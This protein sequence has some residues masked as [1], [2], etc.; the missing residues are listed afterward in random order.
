MSDTEL[1]QSAWVVALSRLPAMGPVR[2]SA[3][4]RRWSPPQA[5][6]Q[7]LSARVHLDEVIVRETRSLGPELSE[8]WRQVARSID[9]ADLW[10]AHQSSD[11]SVI[12]ANDPDFPNE[13]IDDP[14]PPPAL[15]YR[16]PL[17]VLSA[18][19]VAIVG[20]RRCTSAGK[21]IAYELGF[22]LAKVGV[23]VISGLALGID[24][25]AHRGALAAA[26]DGGAPPAGVVGTGLDVA[27]PPKNRQ[28]WDEVGQEGLLI[29][30]YPLGTTPEPWR[31]PARNRIIASLSEVVVVVE[32]HMQGGSLHTVESALER[33]KAVMAVPGSVRSSASVGTNELLAAGC[34][35][36]RD[37]N[38]VLVALGLDTVKSKTPKVIDMAKTSDVNVAKI[39]DCLGHE[40]ATLEQLSVRTR[41]SPVPLAASLTRLKSQGVV[42]CRGS[43]WERR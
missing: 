42:I 39:L 14:N 4:L 17:E 40:P 22:E 5:W 25:A 8:R 23:C 38:D 37:V 28:L 21:A 36:A 10:E 7:V 31:F 29:S 24:G 26:P 2:L 34:P 9:V 16:G 11:V 18:P 20:T 6:D 35:P 1:P 41:L 30:E 32:S 43:W 3:L 13:L 19:R 12:L 27:Y 33:D 15:F